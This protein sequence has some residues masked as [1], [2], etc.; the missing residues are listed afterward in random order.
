MLQ[1]Q[2]Y[3]A[4]KCAVVS[5]LTLS[6]VVQILLLSWTHFLK[7]LLLEL[8]RLELLKAMCAS[9]FSL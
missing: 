5:H 4:F 1:M 3:T 8:H 7:G 6:S 9:T 2:G